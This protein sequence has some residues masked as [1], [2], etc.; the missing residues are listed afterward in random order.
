MRETEL[1]VVLTVYN[2]EDCLGDFLDSLAD[3]SQADYEVICVNDGSSDDS[4]SIVSRYSKEFPRFK[5]ID[6]ENAGTAA[7]RNAGIA[8][9]H[10]KYLMLLDSDD[11]LEPDLLQTMVNAA[12]R[13]RADVV[14]C[15]SDEFN[16]NT[17]IWHRS[18]W[19]TRT[20]LLPKKESFSAAEVGENLFKSFAG[21]PWDKLYRTSFIKENEFSFPPLRNSE[22]LCFVYPALVSASSIA[23]VDK[24]LVHHRT[25]RSGSVSNSQPASPRAFYDAVSILKEH[26]LARDDYAVFERGFLNWALDFSLW[27]IESLPAGADRTQLVNELL[28]DGLPYLEL[29]EHPREYF[30]LYPATAKRLLQLEAER[31]GGSVST[32]RSAANLGAT[33]WNYVSTL[34]I[35]STARH[36]LKRRKDV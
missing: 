36:A 5:L 19:V 18:P 25:C 14:V 34:D 12:E 3:Q 7:A 1:S 31:A 6:Q 4:L 21:W 10:G 13:T 9:A 11:L 23:V 16:H 35:K 2:M 33:L 8:E 32:R 17:G 30:A 24:V 15:R 20:D 22:D 28:A 26:L 29:N 27:N